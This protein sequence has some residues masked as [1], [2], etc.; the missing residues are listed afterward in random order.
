[1]DLCGC[2][3]KMSDLNF[4]MKYGKELKENYDQADPLFD[5]WMAIERKQH[6]EF[7][8]Q[9]FKQNNPYISEKVEEIRAKC[10]LRI[11]WIDREEKARHILN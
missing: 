11:C 1:M 3:T 7:D 5:A 8:L 10:G 6:S 2:L 4:C 9:I